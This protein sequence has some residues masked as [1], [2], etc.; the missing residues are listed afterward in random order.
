MS[1]FI[2]NR[3]NFEHTMLPRQQGAGVDPS[4]LDQAVELAATNGDYGSLVLGVA[5]R[6]DAETAFDEILAA[7][8]T[9][10][11]DAMIDG[12]LVAPVVTGGVETILGVQRDP[13]FGPIVMFGLGGIFVEA[14]E[15]VTFRAAP[16]DGSQARVMIES[17][18][19]Y[20]LLTGL[21]GRPPPTSP[22]SRPPSPAFPS[23]PPPTPPPSR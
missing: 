11:P 18:A 6:A 15:D 1:K 13:V 7:C 21:R 9:G 19:A 8:R 3:W 14:L 2:I 22:P 4:L 16:I 5:D 17:V 23:S 12:C 10:Q 20:P